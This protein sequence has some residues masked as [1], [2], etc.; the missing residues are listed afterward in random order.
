MKVETRLAWLLTTSRILGSDANLS[1]RNQFLSRLAERGNVMDAPRLSRIESGAAAA[2]IAVY[3]DYEALLGLVPGSLAATAVGLRRAFGAPQPLRDRKPRE[4]TA[5]AELDSLLEVV[6]GGS[7]KG[8]EWL[9]V[10]RALWYYDHVYLRPD[11]WSELCAT[12]VRELATATG[13]DYVRR[14]EAAAGLLQHPSAQR[15]LSLAIGNFVMDP[16]TQ[17]VAPVLNLLAEVADPGASELVLRLLGSPSKHLHR[18]ASSVAASKVARGHFDHQAL[19]VL[20]RHVERR[21]ARRVS[22]DGGLDSLDL[23]VHLPRTSWENVESRLRDPMA[24]ALVARTRSTRE[25]I[26]SRKAS[27]LASE[28]ATAIQESTPTHHPVETDMMLHRLV[29]EALVHTHKPRR[30]HA[31]LLLAAS[32]YAPAVAHHCHELTG[33]P[34]EL[35]AARAWTVLMRVRPAADDAEALRRGALGTREPQRPR[36]LVTVGL[37][38]VPLNTTQARSAAA[39]LDQARPSERHATLFALGMHG[40]PELQ[41]LAEHDDDA[42]SRGARWWLEHG[43]A[44]RDADSVAAS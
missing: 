27:A 39:G 11:D 29:R 9:R 1:R 19:P 5:E 44:T 10:S 3:A 17:V 37:H 28:V 38:D 32:P 40:S 20:E 18:A 6:S 14:F 25:L 41:A 42:V 26:A 30:H 22:L 15:H 34:D 36:A 24:T 43:G 7:A 8:S 35:I 33:S 2:P 12:L 21:L 4:G 23:A 31:A 16:D 13:V